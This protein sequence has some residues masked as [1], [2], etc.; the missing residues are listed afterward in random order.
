M[1]A[2]DVVCLDGKSALQVIVAGNA[3][4][5]S[6]T[7]DAD[8]MVR[9]F[10]ALAQAYD[11]VVLYGDTE[12]TASFQASLQGRLAMVIAVLAGAGDPTAAMTAIAELTS[13]GAPVFPYDK[14]AADTRPDRPHRCTL[15]RYCLDFRA[16]SVWRARSAMGQRRGLALIAPFEARECRNRQ[17][18][19]IALRLKGEEAVEQSLLDIGPLILVQACADPNVVDNR[20]CRL[21]RRTSPPR[22]RNLQIAETEAART[23]IV[24]QSKLAIER[25]TLFVENVA[26]AQFGILARALRK[27][28]LDECKPLGFRFRPSIV[29]W[30]GGLIPFTGGYRAVLPKPV[31]ALLEDLAPDAIEVLDRL[32]LR[33][34][35]SWGH[36]ARRRH[37]DDLV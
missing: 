10:S 35:G 37:R 29:E 14:S 11:L 21:S 18:H 1:P 22:H 24:E 9:I 17:G 26:N 31:R 34:L 3:P 32:M 13:F 25:T 28:C 8:R 7:K 4:A 6:E 20:L 36:R 5:K 33:S 2:L 16:N 30:T 15:S 19:Q 23:V 12:S 27:Q